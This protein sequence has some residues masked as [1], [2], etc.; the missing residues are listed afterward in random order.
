MVMTGVF[1]LN[2]HVRPVAE[3]LGRMTLPT[4]P[5]TILP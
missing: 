5:A 1:A 3:S 4:K 2:V